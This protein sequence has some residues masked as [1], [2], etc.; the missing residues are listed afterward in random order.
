MSSYDILC[1]QQGVCMN[2]CDLSIIIVSYNEAKY[3]ERAVNSCLNQDFQGEYEII[4]GDDGSNDGSVEIIEKL[5][6]EHSNIIRHFVME[7]SETDVIPSLRASNVIK[8]ALLLSKGKFIA[9][10]SADDYYVNTK[11]FSNA[12]IFLNN[13]NN[14]K[15]SGVF[16]D[17]KKVYSDNTEQVYMFNA[18]TIRSLI[19]AKLYIHISTLVFK[20]EVFDNGFLTD[21]TCDDVE[22]TYSVCIAGK[23][24]YLPNIDF[25]YYQRKGSIMHNND[26]LE[27]AIGNVWSLQERLNK[28]RFVLSALSCC[29]GDLCEVYKQ[30]HTL[31]SPKYK[32]Y[33]ISCAKYPNDFLGDIYHYDILSLRRKIVL[34]TFILSSKAMSMAFALLKGII[35]GLYRR[36]NHQ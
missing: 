23:I 9:V 11:H 17:F 26:S 7:R 14:K 2:S 15:Y 16:S 8:R 31:T 21:R 3:I 20:R 22:M 34:R 30:R 27:Y 24:K 28:G 29:C 35:V 32:K 12:V 10:L 6:N 36:R 13:P 19:I 5:E 25:S 18:P 33:L 1:K 4:I